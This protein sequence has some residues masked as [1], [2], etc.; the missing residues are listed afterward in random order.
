[1]LSRLVLNL[2]QTANSRAISIVRSQ[3]DIGPPVFASNRIL[4]NIG[5]PLRVRSDNDFEEQSYFNEDEVSSGI[6]ADNDLE[7]QG[8]PAEGANR[9]LDADTVPIEGSYITYSTQQSL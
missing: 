3:S 1:M 7:M 6:N 9:Q 8:I 4:G 5:E 2:S